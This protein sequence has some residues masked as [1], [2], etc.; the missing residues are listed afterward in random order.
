MRL[1]IA[2]ND[3]NPGIAGM[4]SSCVTVTVVGVPGCDVI[5]GV[6]VVVSERVCGE[7]TD[8]IPGVVV[9]ELGVVVSID[10]D[11]VYAKGVVGM[12]TGALRSLNG[13]R[14]VIFPGGGRRTSFTG[15]IIGA[16]VSGWDM[17]VRVGPVVTVGETGGNLIG[18]TVTIRGASV[19]VGS[20]GNGSSVVRPG[21]VITVGLRVIGTRVSVGEVVVIVV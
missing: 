15:R 8:A 9:S 4:V 2:E 13:G 12:T 19:V 21:P 10:W 17:E 11:E 3:S 20:T 1:N 14:V 5:G 6:A 7:V 18:V 16:T